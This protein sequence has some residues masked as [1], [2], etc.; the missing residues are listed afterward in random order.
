[1]S[2][3]AQRGLSR[4]T[5]F[6]W[7]TRNCY[8][9]LL[10]EVGSQNEEQNKRG[11]RWPDTIYVHVGRLFSIHIFDHST[12]FDYRDILDAEKGMLEVY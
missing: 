12:A 8:S 2:C 5:S 10:R 11:L 1:M 7:R 9:K 3:L 4:Y 6:F